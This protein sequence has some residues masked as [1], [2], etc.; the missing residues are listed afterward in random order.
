MPY[1]ACGRMGQTM[2]KQF[3]T[4]KLSLAAMFLALALLLPFLTGQTSQLGSMFCPMHLPIFLCGFF[5]GGW[6]GFIVGLIAPVFRSTIFGM[7]QMF[8]VAVCMSFELAIFGLVTGVLHSKL[9][10]KK[11]MIY[12]SLISAMILGRVVWGLVM[13]ACMGF[14]VNKFGLAAFLS[15][16]VTTGIPGIIIQLVLIPVIVMFLEKP[17]RVR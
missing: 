9:P 17:D 6:W 2:N 7:P 12:I 14:D 16:A 11:W 1:A 3:N 5:C 13:F 15:G 4:K 8:P 10:K